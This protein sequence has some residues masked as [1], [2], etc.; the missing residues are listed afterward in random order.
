MSPNP[1]KR[2]RIEERLGNGDMDPPSIIDAVELN[3]LDMAAHALR[4]RPDS[5]N[6][7]KDGL[8]PLHLAVSRGNLSMVTYLTNQEGIDLFVKDKLE[9]TPLELAL[10]IG[11]PKVKDLL[12]QRVAE[13]LDLGPKGPTL[14]VP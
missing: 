11:H 4:A 10:H 8:T 14:V 1:I 6:H 5:L 12:F 9:R 13:D 2:T 7:L 3:D